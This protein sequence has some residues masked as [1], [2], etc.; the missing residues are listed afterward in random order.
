MAREERAEDGDDDNKQETN[1][2]G[3]DASRTMLMHSPN[4]VAPALCHSKRYHS[5]SHGL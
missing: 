2:N 5:Q 3:P 4:A 1:D